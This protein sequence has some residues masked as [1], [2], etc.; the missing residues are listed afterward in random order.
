M[1]VQVS[2]QPTQM[3]TQTAQLP[4]TPLI[5]DE[6]DYQILRVLQE[7]ARLSIR[8]VATKVFL[9]PTPTHE[10]IKR[11]EQYG[12]IRHYGAILNPKKVNKGIMVICQVT[13]TIHNKEAA[14]QFI[15]AV[16][17]FKEVLECYNIAGDYDFM[18]KIVTESMESYHDFFVNKL[19]A[20]A[21]VG[22][23]KSTFVMDVIKDTHM[24]L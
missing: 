22:Q 15:D 1:T 24:I 8:E 19:T 5:L 21:Y 12:V 7:N 13:V 17:S 23:T 9:S 4:N 14:Q 6:K 20:V 18:L 11:L 10:R 3:D 2:P 16:T